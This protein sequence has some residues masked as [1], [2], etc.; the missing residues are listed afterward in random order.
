MLFVHE[1]HGIVG[2]EEEAFESAWQQWMKAL[3]DG[4]DA[5]LLWYLHHTHGTGPAYQVV[6]VTGVSDAAAWGRLAARA[7]AGDLSD[8]R[9]EIDGRRHDHAAKVLAPVSWSPLD[10]VDLGDVPLDG[11]REQHLFM[12]DTAWPHRGRYRDYLDK[13]GSLYLGLLQRGAESGRGMLEMVAAFS[14][15]LGSGPAREVVLWQRITHPEY[16]LPLFSAEVPAE[17][18]Q[19]GTWMHDALDVRDRWESRLLRTAPWSPLN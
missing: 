10:S 5:R 18:K 3:G 17:H 13:A 15:T 6:T 14:P 19:P 1:L 16:L 11:E 12:E 2:R 9:D 4:E 7:R 8:L